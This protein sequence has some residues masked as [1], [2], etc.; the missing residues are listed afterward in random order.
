[1]SGSVLLGNHLTFTATV[2]NT[3][4]TGVTWSVNG[5]VGGSPSVGTI[6]ATGDY[7]APADL[8]APTTVQISAASHADAT[9]SGSATA[10]IAS[11]IA[12]TLTPNTASVELGATQ[13]FQASVTSAGHPDTTI[14]WSL[15]GGAC[16]TACGTVDSSGRF[17]APGILPSPPSATVT[18]QSV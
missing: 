18:A 5:I 12:L 10:T 13:P 2:T 6:A 9:K 15:S 17:T 3:A 8:P 11:D 16:S 4:D 7:T 1:P 14:H